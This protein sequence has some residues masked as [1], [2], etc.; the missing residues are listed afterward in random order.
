MEDE[1]IDD[2]GIDDVEEVVFVS[3]EMVFDELLFEEDA[4]EDEDCCCWGGEV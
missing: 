1:A 3:V 4:E 2:D